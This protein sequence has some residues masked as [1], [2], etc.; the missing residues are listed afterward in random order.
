MEDLFA[1]ALVSEVCD[2]NIGRW[3]YDYYHAAYFGGALDNVGIYRGARHP[4]LQ[5]RILLSDSTMV[6]PKVMLG[7]S[8]R[9]SITLY[10]LGLDTL[11]VSV[12]LVSHPAFTAVP[13]SPVPSS[14]QRSVLP[15]IRSRLRES[16][17]ER[18]RAPDE[19]PGRPCRAH[20]R[21]RGRSDERRT[22]DHSGDHRY[23]AGPGGAGAGL[24]VSLLP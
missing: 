14:G 4:V 3:E 9:Q 18:G 23:P 21:A 24:V 1:E 19:R 7:D 16:C 10:N 20:P 12:N 11:R 15:E 17:R 13:P 5:A 22:A 6:F 8:A 2:L